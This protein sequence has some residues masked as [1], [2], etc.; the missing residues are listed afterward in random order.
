MFMLNLFN[1]Y[2]HAYHHPPKFSYKGELYSHLRKNHNLTIDIDLA[3]S[4]NNKLDQFNKFNKT[5]NVNAITDINLVGTETDVARK[6]SK[7]EIYKTFIR[8]HSIGV[9]IFCFGF[10]AYYHFRKK[11][12]IL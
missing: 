6:F 9:F 12:H 5:N 2:Y 4:Y 8:K 3:N 7:I 1:K 11:N 10:L